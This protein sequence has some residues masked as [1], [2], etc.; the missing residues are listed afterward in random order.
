MRT[1]SQ[2]NAAAR[3][4]QAVPDQ[5]AQTNAPIKSFSRKPNACA[6]PNN[7]RPQQN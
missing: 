5:N 4:W 7:L 2:A 1:A 3:T 6:K